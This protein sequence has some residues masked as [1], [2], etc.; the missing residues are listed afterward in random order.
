M[1]AGEGITTTAAVPL[2]SILPRL[3]E[4][5]KKWKPRLEGKG[6]WKGSKINRAHNICLINALVSEDQERKNGRENKET[7]HLRS[8]CLL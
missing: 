7:I 1:E 8:D 5:T 2:Q 3:S 6:A 4:T